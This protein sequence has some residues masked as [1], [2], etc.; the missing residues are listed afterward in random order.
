MQSNQASQRRAINHNNCGVN[1]IERG[2]YE[3]AVVA[4]S[5]ALKTCRQ[6]M[7]ET[8]D[9]PEPIMT[10]LDQCMED[11]RKQG[12]FYSRD[13]CGDLNE[14]FLYEQ[15]IILPINLGSG[16]KTS[17]M[18]SSMV[19]FNLALANQLFAMN[20]KESNDAILRKAATLY[21]LGFSM[22]Q[23]ENF[24]NNT[25]FTLATVNNMGLI[26][27]RLHD[28]QA[29]NKCFEYL[30]STLMYLTDCSGGKEYALFEGFF[31][32]VSTVISKPCSAAAA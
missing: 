2:N 25:L 18:I 16:Y 15:A 6:M 12:S 4:L 32:N 3:S 11:S 23:D 22:Q 31:R 1:L 30:L 13:S 14:Q 10:S 8:H 26:H 21:E 17:V 5:S 9:Y 7:D 29:A 19:T 24:D 27:N 28:R 20:H